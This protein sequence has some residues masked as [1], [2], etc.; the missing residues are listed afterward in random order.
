MSAIEKAK[1]DSEKERQRQ[2]LREAIMERKRREALMNEPKKQKIEPV[3]TVKLEKS[4][5]QKISANSEDFD[6]SGPSNSRET[7]ESPLDPN[8]FVGEN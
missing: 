1:K 2:K 3:S 4:V 6:V 7:Q 8:D 5:N